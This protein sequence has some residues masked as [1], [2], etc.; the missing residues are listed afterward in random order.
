M[1]RSRLQ[2]RS[3]AIGI[4]RKSHLIGRKRRGAIYT[5]P[6]GTLPVHNLPKASQIA[7]VVYRRA[8]S[9]LYSIFRVETHTEE[10]MA[11]EKSKF[12]LKKMNRYFDRI[13]F[14]H[15]GDITIKDFKGMAQRFVD[16]GTL[17]EKNAELLKETMLKVSTTTPFCPLPKRLNLYVDLLN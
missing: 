6:Y 11:E 5:W 8:N 3:Q 16:T 7:S 12:W 17:S 15:D 14:D 9:L 1:I 10:I 2:R 13:D 4:N